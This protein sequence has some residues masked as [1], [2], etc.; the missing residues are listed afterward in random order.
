[1]F[2]TK[3]D[4]KK[5]PPPQPI[6]AVVRDTNGELMFFDENAGK[7]YLHSNYFTTFPSK[8]A[9]S[10]AINRMCEGHDPDFWRTHEAEEYEEE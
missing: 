10:R 2:M 8:H 3:K 4:K 7:F 1:M 6:K 9:A 5:I